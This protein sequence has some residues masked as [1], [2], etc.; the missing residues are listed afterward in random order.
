MYDSNFRMYIVNKVN[1]KDK[2]IDRCR[3]IKKL[4]SK[5]GQQQPFFFLLFSLS[6]IPLLS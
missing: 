3:S 4:D 5:K 2:N 1:E 6:Y